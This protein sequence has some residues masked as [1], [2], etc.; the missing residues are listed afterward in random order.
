MIQPHLTTFAFSADVSIVHAAT[1]LPDPTAAAWMRIARAAA[2]GATSAPEPLAI[3]DLGQTPQGL[4]VWMPM[5]RSQ[6]SLHLL[7]E[8]GVLMVGVNDL[9]WVVYDWTP[10]P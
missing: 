7:G 6:D 8:S 4:E 1:L 5:A 3:A 2:T 10:G 9:G